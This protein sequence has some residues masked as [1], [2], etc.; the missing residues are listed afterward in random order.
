MLFVFNMCLILFQN[1]TIECRNIDCAPVDCPN[2]VHRDDEC[3]PV[4]LSKSMINHFIIISVI[5]V[6]S[7]T[8]YLSLFCATLFEGKAVLLSIIPDT[9]TL[10]YRYM[11]Y[12]ELTVVIK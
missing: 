2:P 8:K 11:I 3:C 1:G 9:C 6:L 4:C 12:H 7:L 5:T 10:S